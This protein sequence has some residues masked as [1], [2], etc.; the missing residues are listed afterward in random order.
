VILYLEAPDG[1][2]IKAQLGEVELETLDLAP[3]A[4]LWVSWEPEA[5]HLLPGE[6]A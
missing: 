3:G 5:A 6:G 4:T 2:E 1:S